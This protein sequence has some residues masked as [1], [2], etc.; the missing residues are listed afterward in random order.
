MTVM[1]GWHIPIEKHRDKFIALL[2]ICAKG[3]NGR[4]QKLARGDRCWQ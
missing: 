3:G 2:A 1:N 4:N